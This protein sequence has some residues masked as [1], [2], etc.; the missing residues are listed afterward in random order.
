M[1]QKF[2]VRELKIKSAVA[3]R[4]GLITEN[5]TSTTPDKLVGTTFKAVLVNE[6]GEQV[7]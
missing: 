2:R 6:N 1:S 4:S 3:N 5:M 7:V